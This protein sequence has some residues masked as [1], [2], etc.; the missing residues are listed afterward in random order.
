VLVDWVSPYI[1]DM[2]LQGRDNLEMSCVTIREQ[3]GGTLE[4]GSLSSS[5]PSMSIFDSTPSSA[6]R[7]IVVSSSLAI[8]AKNCHHYWT[9]GGTVLALNIVHF[10]QCSCRLGV[11]GKSSSWQLASPNGEGQSCGT[12]DIES[13]FSAAVVQQLIHRWAHPLL[14]ACLTVKRLT[15]LLQTLRRWHGPSHWVQ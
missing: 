3:E 9:A 15:Q 2:I 7:I 4:H 14:A 11:V 5:L 12:R 1:V 13:W 8:F 6:S 10:A